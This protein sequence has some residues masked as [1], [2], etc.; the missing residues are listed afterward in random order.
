MCNSLE[1]AANLWR[2]LPATG[3][4]NLKLVHTVRSQAVVTEKGRYFLRTWRDFHKKIFED[5]VIFPVV[6]GI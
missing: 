1:E 6:M 2:H 3:V 4:R 5:A